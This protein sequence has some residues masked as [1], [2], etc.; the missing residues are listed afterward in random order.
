MQEIRTIQHSVTN[1]Y[2]WIEHSQIFYSRYW[3]IMRLYLTQYNMH[4]S[5][6]QIQIAFMIKI[7][8][9]D[10]EII[11]L[12]EFWQNI[13]MNV[14]YYFDSCDFWSAYFKQFQSKMCFLICKMFSLFFWSM[15]YSAS[16]IASF[17]MQINDQTIYIHNIYFKFSDNY[18]HI[19]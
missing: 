8:K 7:V 17:I 9:K 5:K 19:D 14:I 13:H 2:W 1:Y 4:K 12:Q 3:I 15:K 16:N 10:C 11:A 18:T 6:K